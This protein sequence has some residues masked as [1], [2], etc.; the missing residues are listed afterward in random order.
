MDNN[1]IKVNSSDVKDSTV[2]NIDKEVKKMDMKPPST[3]GLLV[4][5]SALLPAGIV[6]INK[7]PNSLQPGKND[8]LP[9]SS[10]SATG[11]P[12]NKTA[13]AP[14]HS[15]MDWIRLGNSG[16]DLTGVGGRLQTVTPTELVKHNKIDDAWIAIRGT[17]YNITRYM[18]FHPGGVP[19]LMKGVGI[20]ATKLFDDVHAWVNYQSILQKCVVGRLE[21]TIT[22]D[23]YFTSDK[24]QHQK[25]DKVTAVV[26]KSSPIQ[27]EWRQTT[28]NITFF[29]RV[30]RDEFIGE[31]QFQKLNSSAFCIK[32]NLEKA[33]KVVL[34]D[35]KLSD[36]VEWPPNWKNTNEMTEVEII[37]KKKIPKIWKTYGTLLESQEKLD[38]Q[39]HTYNN[40]SILVNSTLCEDVHLLILQAENLIQVFPPGR[41]L[42]IKMDV[43]GTEVLRMYTPVPNFIDLQNK[44]SIIAKDDCLCLIIKNYK[45][46]TL[47]PKLTKLE[48][49]ENLELSNALGNFQAPIFDKY[50]SMHMLAAGTGLTPMLSIIKRSLTLRNPP[51]INL[52]NF[53]KKESSIFCNEQLQEIASQRSLSVTHIL[54]QAESSWSGLKGVVTEQLLKDKI[55]DQSSKACIFICGPSGFMKITRDYLTNLKWQSDQIFEFE[56]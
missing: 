23:M 56:G 33:N 7:S 31:Y 32:L 4:K 17:V 27:M 25:N 37:L 11:N 8:N 29:Y 40:Y 24:V 16:I 19:E 30:N 47:T 44:L 43:M 48:V 9:K 3:I 12:R 2:Q 13:L 46:G 22:A 10:G 28:N 54:S 41:H 55:G 36:E 26:P 15:L 14:G 20:D 39:K 50:S 49:G 51:S 42:A 21:R 45:E 52:I 1:Q 35:F 5:N 38:L 6:Q 34:N 53:N 18:N